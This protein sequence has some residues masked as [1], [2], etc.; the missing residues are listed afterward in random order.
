MNIQES[1]VEINELSDK[2]IKCEQNLIKI[3]KE[4]EDLLSVHKKKF[5]EKEKKRRRKKKDK[6]N[7]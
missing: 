7:T 3:E 6:K 1:V 2:L 4:I 5:T